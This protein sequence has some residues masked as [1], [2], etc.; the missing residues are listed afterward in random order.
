MDLLTYEASLV[1]IVFTSTHAIFAKGFADN[2]PQRIGLALT[3]F[4]SIMRLLEVMDIYPM[5]SNARFL[6]GYGVCLFCIGTYYKFW[7]NRK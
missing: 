6:Q 4:G 7:K 5:L 3:S 1:I 2:L